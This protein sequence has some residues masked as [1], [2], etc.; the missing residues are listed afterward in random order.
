MSEKRKWFFEMKST[1]G[2]YAMNIF[3]IAPKN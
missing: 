2:E 3:E 1:S